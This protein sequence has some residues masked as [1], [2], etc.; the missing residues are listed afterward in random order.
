MPDVCWH[1]VAVGSVVS[2][3][4][5]VNSCRY[6]VCSAVDVSGLGSHCIVVCCGALGLELKLQ[7]HPQHGRHSESVLVF[8][9]M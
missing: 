3:K 2:V 1:S 8:V 9:C 7:C 4:T 6:F 5:V